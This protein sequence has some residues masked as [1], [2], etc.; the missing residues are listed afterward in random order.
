[1]KI[2]KQD[3]RENIEQLIGEGVINCEEIDVTTDKVLK[4]VW[5]LIDYL[6]TQGKNN[7]DLGVAHDPQYTLPPEGNRVLIQTKLGVITFAVY[8]AG[9]FTPDGTS[10][11]LDPMEVRAWASF[12]QI[13]SKLFNTF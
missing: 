11:K 8:V 12:D 1:M 2:E 6:Q 4:L 10:I 3:L 9:R 13:N 7:V 5:V